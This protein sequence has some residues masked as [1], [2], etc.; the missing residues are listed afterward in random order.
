MDNELFKKEKLTVRSHAIRRFW[1]RFHIRLDYKL[2]NYIK[3]CVLNKKTLL[4]D[5]DRLGHPNRSMHIVSIHH[6]SIPVVYDHKL[7]EVVTCLPNIY[8]L[9]WGKIK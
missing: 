3:Y 9:D 4:D 8:T 5:Y 6:R 7:N 1:E 2:R